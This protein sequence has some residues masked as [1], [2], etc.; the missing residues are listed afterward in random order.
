MS[1]HAWQQTLKTQKHPRG[2][3]RSVRQTD[4]K[5]TRLTR[6]AAENQVAAGIS[7][8]S[9]FAARMKPVRIE[10][11]AGS[12]A[13]AAIVSSLELTMQY[14]TDPWLFDVA[15]ALAAHGRLCRRPA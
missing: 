15:G 9:S 12:T 8:R 2:E 3:G 13:R 10:V 7:L 4:G 5:H 1:R 6:V 11:E 14:Y